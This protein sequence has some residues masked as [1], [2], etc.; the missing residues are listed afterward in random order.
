MKETIK[1]TIIQIAEEKG[2]YLEYSDFVLIEDRYL[3]LKNIFY[4]LIDDLLDFKM[5][6]DKFKREI[7]IDY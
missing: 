2:I 1:Q 3:R 4:W 7:G 5:P 6:K